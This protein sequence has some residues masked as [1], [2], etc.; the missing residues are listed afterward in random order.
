MTFF[1]DAW[2]DVA[3]GPS[4]INSVLVLLD[5]VHEDELLN[6]INDDTTMY[7]MDTAGS[8]GTLHDKRLANRNFLVHFFLHPEDWYPG[9]VQNG[10]LDTQV[11]QDQG[12]TPWQAQSD[13][14]G[15]WNDLNTALQTVVPRRMALPPL[16][17]NEYDDNAQTVTVYYYDTGTFKKQIYPYSQLIYSGGGA[18]D[19]SNTRWWAVPGAQIWDYDPTAPD[20]G[21]GPGWKGEG[22]DWDKDMSSDVLST[23]IQIIADAVAVVLTLTGVGAAV[24][25][26]I[27]AAG[28]LVANAINAMAAAINGGD[29]TGSLTKMADATLGLVGSAAHISP[30]ITGPL[31]QASGSALKQLAGDLDLNNH[32]ELPD[33]KSALDALQGKINSYPLAD[34]FTTLTMVKQLLN[35][36]DTTTQQPSTSDS[37]LGNPNA[38]AAWNIFYAGYRYAQYASNDQIATVGRLLGT[39]ATGTVQSLWQLG[40]HIGVLIKMQKQPG[41]VYQPA[42]SWIV[43]PV[44]RP[45]VTLPLTPLDDLMSYVTFFLA[46]RY[47]IPTS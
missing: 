6:W 42:A 26:F 21:A 43:N 12:W 8:G 34:E 9:N 47:N 31:I 25:P 17:P 35:S 40:A 45:L 28:T 15:R 7:Y 41:Y 29:P 16:L 18:N 30:Q 4:Q 39:Y 32:P 1:T 27:V 11:L 38:D 14:D 3:T 20:V 22:Y 5:Y 13:V 10:P 44:V 36:S 33:I 23:V 19:P 24:A 37:I 2:E 46:P